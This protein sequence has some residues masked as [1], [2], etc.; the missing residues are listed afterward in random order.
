MWWLPLIMF[1]SPTFPFILYLCI[2]LSEAAPRI[3]SNDA[4][5]IIRNNREVS[6]TVLGRLDR[7]DRTYPSD[8]N[9]ARFAFSGLTP[10]PTIFSS[11]SSAHVARTTVTTV[12]PPTTDPTTPA[13]SVTPLVGYLPGVY[14]R[15]ISDRRSAD[16]VPSLAPQSKTLQKSQES[17]NRSPLLPGSENFQEPVCNCSGEGVQD[18]DDCDPSTGQCLC[19]PGYMGLQCEDCEEAH[20]TNGTSGC[21]PC[22]CDTFGALSEL[23]DR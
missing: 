1:T 7:N 23:C 5:S 3:I 19:L 22:G 17:S 21:L 14:D 15:Q 9:S 13:V 2:G 16:S 11:S 4:F 20:F 6:D 18:P 8:A 10:G 12:E